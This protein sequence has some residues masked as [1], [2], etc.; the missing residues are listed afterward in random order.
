MVITRNRPKRSMFINQPGFL[1]DILKP[2]QLESTDTAP[3]LATD[4]LFELSES[5]ESV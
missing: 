5:S 3:S 1:E 4:K 2:F